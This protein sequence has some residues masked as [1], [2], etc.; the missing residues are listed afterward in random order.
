MIR[1]FFTV[2][3]LGVVVA[4]YPIQDYA[5]TDEHGANK[6]DKCKT[7]LLLL[8]MIL[9]YIVKHDTIEILLLIRG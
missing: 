4:V 5:Q 8:Y 2:C 1:E 3:W 6:S 7:I 9:T